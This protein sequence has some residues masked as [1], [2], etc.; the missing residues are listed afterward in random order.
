ME[1]RVEELFVR[2]FVGFAETQSN[3]DVVAFG[4]T[5]DP[6]PEFELVDLRKGGLQG[7]V[8]QLESE[9][10]WWDGYL[11]STLRVKPMVWSS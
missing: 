9:S 1:I 7:N 5:L 11:S 2:E 10:S 4:N 3:Y 8:C 6:A